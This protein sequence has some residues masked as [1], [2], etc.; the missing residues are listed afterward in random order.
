M[1]KGGW[2][3]GWTVHRVDGAQEW[4]VLRVDGAQGGRYTSIEYLWFVCA[5]VSYFSTINKTF[6]PFMFCI[7][8]DLVLRYHIYILYFS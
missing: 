7:N 4:M 3:S 1:H 8:V 6:I 5:P 2:C